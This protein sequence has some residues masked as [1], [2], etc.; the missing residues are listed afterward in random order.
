ML[1]FLLLNNLLLGHV[2]FR[3]QRYG[4]KMVWEIAQWG[5]IDYHEYGICGWKGA[6]KVENDI[7]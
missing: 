3:W 2:V 5:H 7:Y 6:K 1:C 4:G